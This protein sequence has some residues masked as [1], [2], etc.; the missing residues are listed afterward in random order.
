MTV[1]RKATSP[2]CPPGTKTSRTGETMK[3]TAGAT[4][5]HESKETARREMLRRDLAEVLERR[6]GRDGL[7]V[8]ALPALKL[9][10]FS[11]PSELAPVIQ[12]PA[13]Y[14][15]VQG[16]KEVF[17]G[18]TSYVYDRTQYLTVAMELPVVSRVLEASPAEPYLCMTLAIDAREL[19]ALLVETGRAMPPEP[20][21]ARP[22][23]VTPIQASFLD[24]F[25]RLVRLLDAPEDIAVI[26]PLIIRE[27]H[28]RLLQ[29]E[30]FGSLASIAVG[31]G[32]MRRVAKAI[33]WIKEHFAEPMRIE[34]LASQVHMSPS[35]LHQHFKAA[36]AMSPIQYQKRLRLET[37]RQRLLS[38][39]TSAE[40]VA[41]DVGYASASQFSREYARLFGQPP[42]RDAEL[43]REAAQ[44]GGRAG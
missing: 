44:S 38:G 7:T 18:G 36:T 1:E 5:P 25:L 17:L 28:F 43:V 14:V 39:A 30:Q 34:A 21:D 4:P 35:A 15:V 37:A 26:A 6:T 16:R 9:Y 23:Y 40:A 24:A 29:G 20:R 2:Y 13:V 10:R 41:Y 12:E 32:R 33:A 3:Q 19:A 22:L 31:D 42:R 27:I 11:A 8:T